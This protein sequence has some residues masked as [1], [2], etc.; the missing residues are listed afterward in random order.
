MSSDI[1]GT[2]DKKNAFPHFDS[3]W[4]D[5]EVP[6]NYLESEKPK[7]FMQMDQ[8]R[9]AAG[10]GRLGP[11]EIEN[12]FGFHK[13]TIEGPNA[14]LQAHTQVRLMFRELGE[15][16]DQLLPANRAKSVAF[17]ELESASMWF[18]KAIAEQAPLIEE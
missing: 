13:A 5:R 8:E 10:G 16:L 14:T 15:T 11:E 2:P 17:Q 6:E 1:P 9:R 3:R 12:R 4:N 7:T 18:H